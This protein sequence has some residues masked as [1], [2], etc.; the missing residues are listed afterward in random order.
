MRRGS[1][2]WIR[3]NARA[4]YHYTGTKAQGRREEAIV[5]DDIEVFVV[6]AFA[7]DQVDADD[8]GSNDTCFSTSAYKS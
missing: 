3:W 6:Q 7:Q 5:A 4:S 1:E 8:C 2:Y